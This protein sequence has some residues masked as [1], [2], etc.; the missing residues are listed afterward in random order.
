[1]NAYRYQI[2][3]F[4]LVLKSF[5]VFSSSVFWFYSSHQHC[6]QHQTD[7][8]SDLLVKVEHL[9]AKQELMET[10]TEWTHLQMN[11]KVVA[12][13]QDVYSNQGKR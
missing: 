9:A 4:H 12:Y 11:A 5:F 13:L 10:K 8:Q 6:F 3:K 7:R 1:M 2:S